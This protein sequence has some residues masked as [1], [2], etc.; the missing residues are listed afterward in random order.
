MSGNDPF[1]DWKRRQEQLRPKDLNKDLGKLLESLNEL[2]KQLPPQPDDPHP[3]AGVAHH[4]DYHQDVVIADHGLSGDL[5]LPAT[6]GAVFLVQQLTD[7]LKSIN[8]LIQSPLGEQ[9][10]DGL[11]EISASIGEVWDQFKADTE[12]VI[13]DVKEQMT[14]LLSPERMQDRTPAE[15]QEKSTEIG[16]KQVDA[17]IAQI[18]RDQDEQELKDQQEK[19]RAGQDAQVAE[20]REQL[21]KKYE[22]SPDQ[23]KYL[24]QFDEAAKLAADALARQQAAQL[25]KLQEQQLNPP[26]R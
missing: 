1:E 13:E 17:D 11:K 7:A 10:I 18:R 22:D 19:D 24:K 5:A 16:G 9:S 26:V 12:Q 3:V 23:E 20:R 8:G 2:G 14:E 4:H 6:L 15:Q 21:A 25:Q